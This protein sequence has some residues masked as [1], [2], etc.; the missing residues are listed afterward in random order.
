MIRPVLQAM[1]DCSRWRW[2]DAPRGA[3]VADCLKGV[4]GTALE[5]SRGGLASGERLAWSGGLEA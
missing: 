5:V 3:A 4:G 1:V 2:S